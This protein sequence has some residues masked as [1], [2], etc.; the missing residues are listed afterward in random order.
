MQACM[1]NKLSKVF[2]VS[3]AINLILWIQLNSYK[4]RMTAA[5]Q[6][7]QEEKLQVAQ[8]MLQDRGSI[9]RVARWTELSKKELEKLRN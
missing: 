4:H 2:A 3:S 6:P 1:P 5:Q 8:R 7:R 9:G